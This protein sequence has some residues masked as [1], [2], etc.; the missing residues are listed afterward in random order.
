MMRR[1]HLAGSLHLQRTVPCTQ[2][3]LRA[4][5]GRVSI[6]QH[7]THHFGKFGGNALQLQFVFEGLSSCEV[8]PNARGGAG[9]AIAHS[10]R[11]SAQCR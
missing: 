7:C 9:L 8:D 11:N 10:E 4:P 2:R 1:N 5:Q 3:C 6:V